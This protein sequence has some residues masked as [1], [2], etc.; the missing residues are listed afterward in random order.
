LIGI[1][2]SS[3]D[4][5]LLYQ[6]QTKGHGH[7]LV[8]IYFPGPGAFPYLDDRRKIRLMTNQKVPTVMAESATLNA[9]QW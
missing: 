7:K 6:G 9:G 5:V 8:G 3:V 1:A 4:S 2:S